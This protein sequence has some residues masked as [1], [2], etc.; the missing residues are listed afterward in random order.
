ML[1]IIVKR[2]FYILIFALLS[3]ILVHWTTLAQDCGTKEECEKKIEEYTQKLQTARAQKDTLSSQIQYMDSQIDLTAVKIKSTEFYIKKTTEEIEK[4]G[5]KIDEL[6]SSLDYLGKI[7][8]E[9]IVESYKN[10]RVS[11]LESLLSRHKGSTFVKRLKYIKTAQENDKNLAYRVQQT[12]VNFEDQKNLREKKKEELNN[13]KSTL[14]NQKAALGSQKN[15]KQKLLEITK[16]DEKVYQSLLEKTRSEYA[17]IQ[18]I[19]AGAGV[20]N[21][22]RDV[23]HGDVIAH[24]IG[25]PSCNSSGGHL[26]FMVK[27]GDNVSNP[28]SYLKST[29]VRNCSGSSCGSSDGDPFNPTGSWDW[30]LKPTIDFSQGFGTTWAVR[31]TWVGRIYNSHSGIDIRGSSDEVLAVADGELFRGS[32][33][34][35]GGCALPYVKLVHTGSN[36]STFYL[37]VYSQ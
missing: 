2:V 1:R 23:K 14:D 9:K 37:H 25:G 6:N 8:L 22:L 24:M 31:N 18:G 33:S 27:D 30:P 12:K 3:L 7:L 26:H 5:L 4:L 16:N 10:R 11:F 19:V 17:A 36:I 34:G 28:F 29:D 20:E 35:G 13:L 21:K 15:A 32:F